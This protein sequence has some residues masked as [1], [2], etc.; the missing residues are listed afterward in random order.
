MKTLDQLDPNYVITIEY[1]KDN[2]AQLLAELSIRGLDV[3]THVGPEPNKVQ[4]YTRV[5]IDRAKNDDIYAISQN[6][7]FIISQIPLY[8]QKTS[9]RL[10]RFVK[11][12]TK[13]EIIGL[14]TEKE[15]VELA[16][17]TGNSDQSLYFAY[18]K[19]YIYSLIPLSIIGVIVRIIFGGD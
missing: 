15:L 7:P 14:P 11:R 9:K 18:L 12:L 8:D 6:L 10:D 5:D 1:S 16:L 3:V 4:V 2:L 13:K 19:Y 17:L